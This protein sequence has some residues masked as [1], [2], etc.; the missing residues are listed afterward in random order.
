MTSPTSAS[1]GL[2]RPLRDLAAWTHH[3]RRAQIPVLRETVEALDALRANEERTDANS[4]GEMIGGDPLMTLKVLAYMSDHRGRSVV[5]GPDTVIAALVMMGIPPFFRAFATPV[6]VE[7]RL[8]GSPEALAGLERVLRRAHRG[9]RFA[10]AFAIHRTDPHAATVHAAA[11]LHEF[12]EMLLWCHAPRLALQIRAMQDADP[13]LRSSVAQRSVLHIEL[14]ELQKT[15][16]AAWRLPSLLSE[17]NQEPQ[18]GH[19]GARSVALGARLAR[20]TA[21]SWDN[22]AVPDDVADVASFLNLSPA[23]AMHLVTEID[24]D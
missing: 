20:H 13:S 3:F 11:L 12:A 7:D 17:N 22:A 4:I 15:L 1:E 18:A 8:A 24:A 16:V 6:A 2:V 9:A 21:A 5:T 23:A 19:T 14:E 10:L